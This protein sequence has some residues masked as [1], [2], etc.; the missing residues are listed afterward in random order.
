MKMLQRTTCL[1]GGYTKR[2]DGEEEYFN[3]SK[4]VNKAPS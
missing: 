3:N 4:N 2:S 1:S